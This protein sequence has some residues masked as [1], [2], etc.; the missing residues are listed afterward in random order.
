MCA[1][2]LPSVGVKYGTMKR[3]K[4]AAQQNEMTT[5]CL[6]GHNAHLA[7]PWRHQC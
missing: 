5:A 1:T 3:E 7:T 4:R 2:D 6:P